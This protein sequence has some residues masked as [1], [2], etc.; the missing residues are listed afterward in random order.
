MTT[1]DTPRGPVVVR[2]IVEADL[3]QYR[4]LRLEALR[5]APGAFGEDH[6]E[7]LARPG[8]E[9]LERLRRQVGGAHSAVLVGASGGTL[10]GMTG[11]YREHGAKRR[12]NA[13]VWGVYVRPGWRGTGV[14]RSLVSSAIEWARSAGVARVSLAVA[15]D[16]VARAMYARLGFREV[17]VM[18]GAL[19]AGGRDLDEFLLELDLRPA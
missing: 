5:L 1:L 10:V 13:T 4:D 12:H 9:W 7:A 8:S 6:S 15:G 19:R 17:G 11:V 16:G 3:A 18:R 14:G 2:P